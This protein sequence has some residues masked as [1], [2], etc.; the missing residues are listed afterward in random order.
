MIEPIKENDIISRYSDNHC[1]SCC[2]NCNAYHSIHFKIEPEKPSI[3]VCLAWFTELSALIVP[4]I[5]TFILG[6]LIH[7]TNFEDL[8][9]LI[10]IIIM[11][12]LNL[13]AGILYLFS[14]I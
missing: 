12:G 3:L 1:N 5:V 10:E 11:V 6:Q 7:Y 14:R 8:K 13:I 2:I 4:F 9:T